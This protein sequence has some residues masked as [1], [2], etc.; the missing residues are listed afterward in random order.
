MV[1]IVNL[2][3]S[4]KT[5]TNSADKEKYRSW[6]FW[7]RTSWKNNNNKND[8]KQEHPD[9]TEGQNEKSGLQNKGN[10]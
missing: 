9:V 7:S 5:T 2:Q 8:S 4:Q 6:V 10:A 1:W 3:E